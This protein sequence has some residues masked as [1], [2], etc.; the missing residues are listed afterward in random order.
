MNNTTPVH[1]NTEWVK[2]LWCL[3]LAGLLLL[4]ACEKTSNDAAPVGDRAALERLAD[5]Y[6]AVSE[7]F[8][9]Q[10]S[11]LRPEGLKKFVEQVFQKAGYDHGATLR[12][13]AASG[14]AMTT[15]DHRD[16]AELLLMPYRGVAAGELEKLASGEE[17]S[18]VITLQDALR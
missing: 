9:A 17:L 2:P 13:F 14:A 4:S 3:L 15:Q 8:P 7:K 1:S 5:A 12:A 11:A 10:P 6:R 18:A 16:L